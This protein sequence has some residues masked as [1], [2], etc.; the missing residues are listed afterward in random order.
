MQSEIVNACKVVKDN[1]F[2]TTGRIV[3]F[4][5]ARGAAHDDYNGEDMA[6][7]IECEKTCEEAERDVP[8]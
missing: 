1:F 4:G 5:G 6:E 3:G 2:I 7:P 8:Q